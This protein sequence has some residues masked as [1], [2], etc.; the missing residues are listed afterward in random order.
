MAKVF[1]EKYSQMTFQNVWEAAEIARHLE[2]FNTR[3]HT[4]GGLLIAP[5][6]VKYLILD[7]NT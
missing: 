5:V 1:W 7:L 6:V 3:I 2:R 4:H